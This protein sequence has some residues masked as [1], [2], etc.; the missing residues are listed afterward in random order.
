[1]VGHI[2]GRLSLLTNPDRPHMFIRELNLYVDYLRKEVEDFTRGLIEI[3]PKYFAEFQTNLYSGIE[4]Y[5]LLA[6]QLVE[7]HRE[8]FLGSLKSLHAEIER[9]IPAAPAPVQVEGS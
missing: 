8:R 9:I 6:E 4:Y 3:K 7:E 2:Y 1:M 5:T